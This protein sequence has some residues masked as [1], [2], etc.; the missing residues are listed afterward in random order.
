MFKAKVDNQGL[1]GLAYSQ[2]LRPGI[3][4]VIGGLFDTTRISADVHKLGLQL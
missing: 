3:K 2:V 4:V 1:L